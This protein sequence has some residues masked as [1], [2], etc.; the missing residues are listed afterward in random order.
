MRALSKKVAP[1]TGRGVWDE[2]GPG[3]RGEAL[4]KRLG[5]N[6]PQNFDVIDKFKGG[7][8]TSIKSMD[9]GAKTYQNVDSIT[10]VGRGYID[11]VA[12]FSGA[13]RGGVTINASQIRGR[14]L[15]LAVPPG[16][17]PAQ[18]QALQGLVT[19]G[20]QNRVTV[21]IIPIQ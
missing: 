7:V 1:S 3:L 16:V 14:A 17:T 10:R 13:S 11:K 5:Q 12:G 4:E 6:L 18:Q 2:L 20:Q 9:L 15:D 21:N 8:G 19:Y